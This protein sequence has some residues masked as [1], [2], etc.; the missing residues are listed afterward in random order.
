MGLI[1]CTAGLLGV[2]DSSMMK[3]PLNI[4]ASEVI[5]QGPGGLCEYGTAQ[6]SMTP[7]KL[8]PLLGSVK[9][10]LAEKKLYQLMSLTDTLQADLAQ[11]S[12]CHQLEATH[13]LAA[14]CV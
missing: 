10:M 8:S 3:D 4:Q 14:A 6:D 1:G 11:Q 9:P 12:R 7:A 2:T 13:E 5:T